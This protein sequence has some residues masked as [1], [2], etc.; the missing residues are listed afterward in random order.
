MRTFIVGSCL[1]RDLVER[2]GSWAD[3]LV[4]YCA[5]S[6]LISAFG[7]PGRPSVA[8]DDLS[9][10]FQ[11]QQMQWDADSAMPAMLEQA[12]SETDLLI[13]D[14]LDERAG[15]YLQDDGGVVTR[16]IDQLAVMWTKGL[17]DPG[18][19]VRFGS[20]EHRGLYRAALHQWLAL[21]ER[22]G[23]MGRT[24]L[25]AP[26]WALR[27]DVGEPVPKSLGVTARQANERT[28]PYLRMIQR[29]CDIPL[30]SVERP[31]AAH[32]HQWGRAP[33]HYVPEVYD[34]LIA[35]IR[36]VMPQA[37]RAD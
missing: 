27:D 16:S 4:T 11:R 20:L 23:L 31:V 13:W 36:D 12:A 9:S 25:L 34:A 14:L 26:P 17:P 15:V 28:R 24:V 7:A 5:R 22:T 18:R 8:P 30:L 3:G 29:Y 21:L 10:S 33:F 1:S 32:E 2:E 19:L 35:Q 37:R 6:S